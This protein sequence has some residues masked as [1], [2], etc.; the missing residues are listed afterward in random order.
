MDDVADIR[1]PH[2]NQLV[3]TRG[4]KPAA[5]RLTMILVHGRG[6]SAEDI[7]ALANEFEPKDIAYVAPRAAY[8]LWYPKSFL[9]PFAQNEPFLGSALGVLS[10]LVD[11]L[12]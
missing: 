11:A 2:A 12:S 9:A 7:L 1:D 6:A 4:P 10:R 5:A 8:S 3:L